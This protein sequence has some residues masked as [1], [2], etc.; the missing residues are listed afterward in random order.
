MFLFKLISS[1]PEMSRVDFLS[2]F[3][4]NAAENPEKMKAESSLG[5]LIGF[6]FIIFFLLILSAVKEEDASG[7]LTPLCVIFLFSAAG[8]YLLTRELTLIS[9]WKL[10][11]RG[12]PRDLALLWNRTI[13]ILL[14]ATF[15]ISLAVP[16][17][18]SLHDPSVIRKALNDFLGSFVIN[19]YKNPLPM[20]EGLPNSIEYEETGKSAVP[21]ALLGIAIG[22]I[23]LHGSF[24]VIG[25]NMQDRLQEK[26]QKRRGTFFHQAERF[27]D[28][29]TQEHLR[30]PERT[31]HP[32]NLSLD[33]HVQKEDRGKGEEKGGSHLLRNVQKF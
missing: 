21:W 32:C 30:I 33:F 18:Y 9:E 27:V 23:I 31:Y 10:A 29:N 13:F 16:H 6:T 15:I 22:L 11:E 20:P 12:V 24:G 28:T 25:G 4:S 3:R 1:E 5:I 17:N 2:R 14:G 19:P 7:P 8:M 26:G